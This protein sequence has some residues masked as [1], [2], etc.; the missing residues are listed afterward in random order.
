MR[1]LSRMSLI[2]LFLVVLFSASSLWGQDAVV[3]RNV[4]L[5]HDPSTA[6]APIR[7]LKPPDEL[8]LVDHTKVSGYYHVRTSE[9]EEDWVWSK[10]IPL[11]ASP[12]ESVPVNNTI[13]DT[14]SKP[15]PNQTTFTSD[16][17]TCGP[18][19]DGG[20]TATNLRKNRTDTSSTYHDVTV[21]SIATLSYPSP[22]P[23]SRLK[24]PPQQL[25]EIKPY[26]G[27]AVRVVG[28]IVALKPQRGGSGESTNCHWTRSSQVD[29]HIALVAKPGEGE[30]DA[31]V[32]ETTPRVRQH[33]PRWTV[34]R[35]R[36]WVNSIEPVRISG[37]LMMDPEHRN[38]LGRYRVTLWEIHPITKIEVYSKDGWKDLDAHH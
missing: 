19:G 26:E 32:V 4:N 29:W 8:N 24:W 18:T 33:H 36:P 14:W 12:V 28:Y 38:H 30:R 27:V 25:A 23:L 15:Q 6:Q 22:A 37:W 17:K 5:R 7:L 13:S 34:S 3:Q 2:P 11:L 9:G 1:L 16:G 21:S 10:N 20:D 31:V 35:L